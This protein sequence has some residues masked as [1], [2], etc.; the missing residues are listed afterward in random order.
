MASTMIECPRCGGRLIEGFVID[1]GDHNAKQ[2][3]KWFEGEPVR[4]FWVGLKTSG[5]D[6]FT[7][8][9]YRCDRCGYLES[10]AKTP[11]E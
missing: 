3:Q 6:S 7:V 10:Y 9:T 1:R 8:Q 4:S 2:L 11:V 5:R